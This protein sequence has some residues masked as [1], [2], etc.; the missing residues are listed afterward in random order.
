MVLFIVLAGCVAKESDR[1][2]TFGVFLKHRFLSRLLPLVFFT[3]VFMLAAAVFPGDFI[4]LKLP[5]LQGYIGGLIN[6]A[7]G[8]PLFCVPSWFLMLIFSVEMVHYWAF[9]MLTTD[10]KIVAGI[11]VFYV[12]GYLFNWHFDI[13]NPL[14]ERVIGWN[15]LFIHEAVFL[16]AFYLLGVFMRHKGFLRQVASRRI[17]VPA[18]VVAALIILFSS[19]GQALWFPL[20]A[21]AGCLMILFIARALPAWRPMVWMGQH[22]LILMCLNGIFYHFIN[23]P[24]VRWV[25]D[26]LAGTPLTLSVVSLVITMVSLAACMPLIVL[27]KRR[28]PQLVGRPAEVGPLLRNLI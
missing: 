1:S 5:S 10:S 16:Y 26:H 14:K 25:V 15:Y 27:L 6:T 22:T 19:H 28:V 18:A 13:V 2:I 7:F 17:L 9:R 23:P 11:V 21:I 20:T 3:V 4:R 12:A 24:A 8:I